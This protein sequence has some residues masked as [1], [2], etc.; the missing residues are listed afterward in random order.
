MFPD[1]HPTITVIS[2]ITKKEGDIGRN[3]EIDRSSS[4]GNTPSISWP[5]KDGHKNFSTLTKSRYLL[6]FF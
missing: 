4:V 3:Y 1:H 6:G 2:R 5:A